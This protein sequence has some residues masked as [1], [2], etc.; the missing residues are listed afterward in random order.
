MHTRVSMFMLGLF[1]SACAP[2]VVYKDVYVPT[3]CNIVKPVR[4]AKDLGLLEYVKALL[5]Y[6][7]GLEKDL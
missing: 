1:L 4:P 2:R 6:T 5:I 7:E 3:P